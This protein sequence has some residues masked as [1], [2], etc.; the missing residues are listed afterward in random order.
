M[1]DQEFLRAMKI[2]ASDLPNDPLV[3]RYRNEAIFWALEANRCRLKAQR[4]NLSFWCAF[5]AWMVTL[6]V[7]VWVVVGK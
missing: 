5:G 2:E 6:A 1:T 4:A 3:A 7:L